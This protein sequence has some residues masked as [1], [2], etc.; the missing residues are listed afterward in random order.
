[1]ESGVLP[2]N[3]MRQARVYRLLDPLEDVFDRVGFQRNRRP[4][5]A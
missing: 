5:F 4:T 1:L 2:F 3:V